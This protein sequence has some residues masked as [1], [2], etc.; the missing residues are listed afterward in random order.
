MY[1]E[2]DGR[3]RG[4]KARLISPN[5]NGRATQCLR[6][7][8]NM[9]GSGVNRLN[10]YTKNG[11]SLGSAIWTLTGNQG[12]DWQKAEVTLTRG[13]NYSVSLQEKLKF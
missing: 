6:F 11:N 8:Y 5:Y 3:H 1:I 12:S 13:K 2:S 7:Y 9:Y 4:Q 10:V